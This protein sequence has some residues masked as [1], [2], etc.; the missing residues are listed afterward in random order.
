VSYLEYDSRYENE[1]LYAANYDTGGAFPR[2]NALNRPTPVV[3]ENFRSKQ[4][5]SSFGEYG[6][7]VTKCPSR[8]SPAEFDDSGMV[9]E[10]FYA[11]VRHVLGAYFP[12]A[13][14]VEILEH[15]VRIKQNLRPW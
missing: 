15:Q 10:V 7:S 9:E 12:D 2:T 6:F 11:E 8:L 1:K 3:I 14:K 4:S 13:A 5:S